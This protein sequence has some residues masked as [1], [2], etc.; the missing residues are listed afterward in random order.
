MRTAAV[1]VAA[2]LALAACKSNP[3]EKLSPTP[4]PAGLDAAGLQRY[5]AYE[6]ALVAALGPLAAAHDAGSLADLID[7]TTVRVQQSS[8]LTP[9]A[10][11]AW[12]ALT[13]EVF[14]V[15]PPGTSAGPSHEEL[16][17]RPGKDGLADARREYGEAAVDAVVG[18]EQELYDL[19]LQRAQLLKKLTAAAGG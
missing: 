13:V 3:P 8:G 4:Q 14:R 18:D 1:L 7:R 2:A 17:P 16:S 9:E 11:H 5:V 6:K 10:L 15:H 19:H 12:E